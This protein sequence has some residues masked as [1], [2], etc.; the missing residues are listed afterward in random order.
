MDDMLIYWKN[1]LFNEREIQK[2][3][4]NWF[5]KSGLELNCFMRMLYYDEYVYYEKS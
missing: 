2:F 4:R 1:D 3:T 5:E